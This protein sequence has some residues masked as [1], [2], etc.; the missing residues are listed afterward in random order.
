MR[1]IE[2]FISIMHCGRQAESLISQ[3]IALSMQAVRGAF[4]FH[5]TAEK[6]EHD[7]RRRRT[8][9]EDLYMG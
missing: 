1:E 7:V 5:Q 9:I 8:H 2:C 3:L 4:Q 6:I